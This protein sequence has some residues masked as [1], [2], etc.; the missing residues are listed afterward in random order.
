MAQQQPTTF[1][2]KEDHA[3]VINGSNGNLINAS[4]ELKNGI[5]KGI[6]W[7]TNNASFELKNGD[8]NGMHINSNNKLS[9]SGTNNGDGININSNNK[10]LYASGTNNDNGMHINANNKKLYASGNSNSNISNGNFNNTLSASGNG[11]CNGISQ[12][13]NN[14]SSA[15]ENGDNK[16]NGDHIIR[17]SGDISSQKVIMTSSA[18]PYILATRFESK[19]NDDDDNA[20]SYNRFCL[21]RYKKKRRKAFDLGYPRDVDTRSNSP[22]VDVTDNYQ[23]LL[24]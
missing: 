10:K 24:E 7:N 20:D 18:A 13:L 14:V 5:N 16:N 8:D 21:R 1:D 6:N 3:P 23:S 19:T 15:S 17:E 4:A 12:N 22:N 11:N 2:N 9:A